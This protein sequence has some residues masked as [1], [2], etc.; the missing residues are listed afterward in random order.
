MSK[1]FTHYNILISCPSD[2]LE[3]RNIIRKAV[4]NINDSNANFNGIHFDIRYWEKDVLFSHGSPQ[5][6]I[7]S[8]IVYDAD[9]VIALFGLKLGTPTSEYE[10]GTIEEIEIMIKNKKQ[11]FVCFSER[12]INISSNTSENMLEN[13][14][15]VKKFKS[16][17][18]GL[19]ISYKKDDELQT[20]IENQ[21]RLFLN[22]I[23]KQKENI[24]VVSMVPFTY[25][26]LQGTKVYL[27]KAKNIIFCART[28]KIFL[29]GHYNILKEQIS[30]G[31]SFCYITSENLN[32]YD[33]ISEHKF[34]QSS[35]VEFLKNL[36]K[37]SN[38]NVECKVL[39]KNINM[40]MLYV[41]M[42]DNKKFI[43]VKFNFQVKM[44]H[45]HPMFLLEEDNSY[46]DIFYLEILGLKNKA[47]TVLL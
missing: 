30:N 39:Q 36:K 9:I 33:D 17:Y 5:K 45:R 10:S 44:K 11:V 16:E 47:K 21:L 18:N 8:S 29:S 43:E 28:G 20:K 22:E 41:E 1:V 37:I 40:T 12:E 25:Q 32:L 35:S 34:N 23:S 13:L 42:P 31:G 38:S 15:K 6:I 24:E 27:S 7:N 26:E 2:I 4:N 19:Y 14:I 3:D 46:F